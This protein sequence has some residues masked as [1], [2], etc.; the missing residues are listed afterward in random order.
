M[1]KSIGT[2]STFM[3]V[4]GTVMKSVHIVMPPFA[5]IDSYNKAILS[6][7]ELQEKNEEANKILVR[8][9]NSLLPKLMS[10]E[11]AVEN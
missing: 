7:L 8:V 4:S 9:R 5:I 10:G 1:I 2:G 11:L 6:F 3:E